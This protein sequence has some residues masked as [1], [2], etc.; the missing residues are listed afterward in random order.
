MITNEEYME[1]KVLKKQG[2]SL[3]AIS[4]RT[5]LSVN[6]VR[7]YLTE[8]PPS[9][10]APAQRASKVDPFKGYLAGRI[11]AARPDWIPIVWRR[12]FIRRPS[13]GRRCATNP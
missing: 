10:K 6:T 11:Q 3:R 2:H 1:L 4:A 5:G 12:A 9:F 7:K 8:G 13:A